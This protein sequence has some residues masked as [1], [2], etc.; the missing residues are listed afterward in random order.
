MAIKIV[1]GTA[2]P[3]QTEKKTRY[4]DLFLDLD[5]ESVGTKTFF[6]KDTKTDLK[7]STDE[8][9]I[10]NSIRNIFSTSPGERILEPTFGLN[11]K[12][13][14][15]QP[16]DDF[17]AQEIGDTIIEGI[18]RYEP[19][20]LVNT[21]NID[22]DHENSQYTIKLVLTIPSLNINSKAYDAILGQPGFDFL[23]HNRI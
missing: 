3:T 22:T 9:A 10:V 4:R 17:T 21:V 13:W 20:V 11:L 15:F 18:E 16:L 1:A 23:T 2:A 6:A 8:A 12:Q 14:M 7:L 19:R 5:E